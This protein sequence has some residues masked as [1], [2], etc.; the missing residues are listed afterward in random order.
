MILRVTSVACLWCD[1]ACGSVVRGRGPRCHLCTLVSS[2]RRSA[3]SDL[4]AKDLD[5]DTIDDKKKR[6]SNGAS[7]RRKQ[8]RF[9]T[10]GSNVL[11]LVTVFVTDEHLDF[12]MEPIYIN[13]GDYSCL[14]SLVLPA[15]DDGETGRNDRG[16][17]KKRK[18]L[19]AT[20]GSI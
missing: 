4:P 1:I 14:S 6:D 11:N 9:R 10:H 19:S 15:G 18:R 16:K 2:R 12:K 5:R 8:G 3:A 7:I 20:T 13:P 17:K